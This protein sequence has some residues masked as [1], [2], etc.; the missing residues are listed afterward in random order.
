MIIVTNF[1]NSS[2][3]QRG[4]NL[5]LDYGARLCWKHIL[6]NKAYWQILKAIQCHHQVFSIYLVSQAESYFMEL[7]FEL[8]YFLVDY[9]IIWN[10]S[11][12]S[13]GVKLCNYC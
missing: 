1:R 10:F 12:W 7:L 11:F 3:S 2:L 5:S 13:N 9:V 4:V 8:F 6:V